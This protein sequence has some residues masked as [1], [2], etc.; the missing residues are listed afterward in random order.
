[1]ALR[2][3]H[4]NYFADLDARLRVIEGGKRKA[5]EP[6]PDLSYLRDNMPKQYDFIMSDAPNK[7][8]IGGIRSGKT[9]GGVL[10]VERAAKGMVGDT[11]IPVPNVG[12]LVGYTYKNLKR[13][14]LAKLYEVCGGFIQRHHK[15]D[16]E[17]TFANGSRLLYASAENYEDIRGLEASYLWIDE[18]AMV[19][20]EAYEVSIGR[21]S[22]SD[23]PFTWVTTTPR[24]MNWLY[25]RYMEDEREIGTYRMWQMS[26]LENPYLSD[27]Y[28]GTLKAEY[29]DEWYKQEVEGEF[30]LFEGMIYKAWSRKKHVI[31]AP[32]LPAAKYDDIVVGV[33]WGIASPGCMLVIGV[34]GGDQLEVIREYY[35]A[36]VSIDDWA[37]IGHSIKQDW[38]YNT[39]FY[40]DPSRPDLIERLHRAHILAIEADNRVEAG[41]TTVAR[42][43]A[44]ADGLRVQADCR[45]TI[46]EFGD[47]V[48]DSTQ[49]LGFVP[50]PVKANDHTMDALRYAVAAIAAGGTRVTM[51][52]YA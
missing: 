22:Q 36:N 7:G 17:I 14:A 4:T 20:E 24:G 30:T 40:C 42:Y 48:W 16:K 2:S 23:Q 50:K 10:C 5:L 9:H 6:L 45:N 28:K 46:R 47:Y 49:K 27:A 21:L 35:F 38:G 37:R 41:I 26:S 19:P 39:K 8:A 43:L 52:R 15:T 18:A 13:G 44:R 31:T 11:A 33:D 29:A 12:L 34:R 32:P 3:R 1:M 25:R 51:R